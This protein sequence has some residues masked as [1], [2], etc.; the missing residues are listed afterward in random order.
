M[1][2]SIAAALGQPV[3]GGAV[4]PGPEEEASPRKS[5]LATYLDH[6]T[7]LDSGLADIVD[8]A[9]P[10]LWETSLSLAPC[11]Q[12]LS[13]NTSL[14]HRDDSLVWL[15]QVFT[16]M[17]FGDSPF[18]LAVQLLDRL[19]STS[20]LAEDDRQVG[21]WRNLLAAVHL[22]IKAN[23]SSAEPY[24]DNPRGMIHH[25]SR[26]AVAF[27][28]VVAAEWEIMRRLDFQVSM[29][30][31]F[32]FLDVLGLRLRREEQLVAQHCE[33]CAHLANFLLH[34]AL[35]DVHVY[36]GSPHGALAAA[37]LILSVSSVCSGELSV[38][39][40]NSVLEDAATCC[41]ELRCSFEPVQRCMDRMHDL[42]VRARTSGLA[43]GFTRHVLQKFSRPCYLCVSARPAPTDVPIL[44][45]PTRE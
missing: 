29:P 24:Y 10:E 1:S 35:A 32:D 41:P 33:Q 28:E 21:G 18:F 2:T 17:R 15:V 43:E 42:W 39:Y 6:D 20:F 45:D 14:R 40:R 38:E 13:V 31:V 26:G 34:L 23:T 44:P 8:K 36:H 4:R 25:L 12:G 11:L 7:G 16:I 9:L 30:S 22:A 3:G 19:Y 27:D 5:N 37:A